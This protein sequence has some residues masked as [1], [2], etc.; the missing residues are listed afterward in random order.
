[1]TRKNVL[2]SIYWYFFVGGLVIVTDKPKDI[3][4]SWAEKP[5]RFRQTIVQHP[6]YV[7]WAYIKQYMYLYI[8]I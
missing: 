6:V 7:E 2:S 8:D 3:E 4:M 5:V 1:M